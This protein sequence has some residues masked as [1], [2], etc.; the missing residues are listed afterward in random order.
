MRLLPCLL[1]FLMLAIVTTDVRARSAPV[2]HDDE[3]FTT[4]SDNLSVDD[5]GVLLNDDDADGD[6]LTAILVDSSQATGL[7]FLAPDGSFEYEPGGFIGVESFTYKANDGTQDSN[8]ASITFTVTAGTGVVTYT[9]EADYLAA[10]AALG[11]TVQLESF[12]DE[13]TWGVARTPVTLPS[14]TSQGITWTSNIGSSQVTTGTGPAL[15]GSYGFFAL[16]HGDYLAGPQCLT[17]GVCTDRWRGS[18]VQPLVAIGGWFKSAGQGKLIAFLNDDT[19][20][21]LGFNGAGVSVSWRFL[22]IIDPAGFNSFEFREVEGTSEDAVYIFGDKFSF[23]RG[24][25]GVW[26]DLGHGLGGAA[27][28]PALVGQGTLASSSP[29]SITLSGARANAVVWLCVGLGTVNAPFYGGTFVPNI[30][31]PGF[32]LPLLTEGSGSLVISDTWPAGVPSGFSIYLQD[33]IVD[34]AGPFGFAASNAL[35]GTSP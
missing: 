26:M 10:L 4:Q 6:P 18:S 5:P 13:A 29:M 11:H 34:R 35:Q 33:W 7:L 17:P 19:T 20:T 22:G 15:H 31:P 9:N 32:A 1:A 28:K 2:A 23:A 27:E 21:P 16:P 30:N 25:S 8:I 14:V 3:Y 24:D 12:E